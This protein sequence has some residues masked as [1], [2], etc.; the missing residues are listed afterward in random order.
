MGTGT[1]GQSQPKLSPHGFCPKQGNGQRLGCSGR[2]GIRVGVKV[3]GKSRERDSMERPQGCLLSRLPGA[4]P[5]QR[6]SPEPLG[7][8][9]NV[10]CGH[11][12]A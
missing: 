10:Q 7:A 12:E 5:V 2:H 8:T 11:S 4:G 9:E 1:R 6:G 3:K